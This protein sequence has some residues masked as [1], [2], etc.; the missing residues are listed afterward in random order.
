MP[1][2]TNQATLSYGCTVTNSNVTEGERL[3]N[4]S[5]TKTAV[6]P[7]YSRGESITYVGTLSGTGVAYSG[8]QVTDNLGNTLMIPG[9]APLEYVDGSVLYYINGVLQPA[10]TVTVGESVTFSGIEIPMSG[11]VTLVYASRVT[12]CA[13]L[14]EGS[15]IVN[16]VTATATGLT[17]ELTASAEVSV[18]SESELTL[19]KAIC[20]DTFTANDKITYTLILLR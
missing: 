4:L 1:I 10:P 6:S 2:F 18:R 17:E 20:P 15:V 8:V 19:A 14:A 12:C 3:R 16:T 11:T 5:V 7:D 9:G 13:P